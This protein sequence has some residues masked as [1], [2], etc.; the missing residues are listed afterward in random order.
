[1]PSVVRPYK[2]VDRVKA[3]T[4][5]NRGVL[6]TLTNKT[7]VIEGGDTFGLVTWA[8]PNPFGNDLPLLGGID[9]SDKA[10]RDLYD[11]LLLA[12]CDAALAEGHTRGQ[13]IIKD[14][15]VLMLMQA[16]FEITVTPVG[17]NTKTGKPGHWMIEFDLALN[18]SILLKRLK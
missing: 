16:T 15:A 18:R 10:R 6:D 8:W 3:L 1:M 9:L 2:E 12:V 11:E 4:L 13:S 7:L 5:V 14:E 17:T